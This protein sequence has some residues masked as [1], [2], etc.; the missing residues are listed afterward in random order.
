MND[1]HRRML[2]TEPTIV[3]PGTK[4]WYRKGNATLSGGI[5]DIEMKSAVRADAF[6]DNIPKRAIIKNAPF[7]GAPTAPT[8]IDAD[9]SCESAGGATCQ[10]CNQMRLKKGT[11]RNNISLIHTIAR[12][13]KRIVRTLLSCRA[14][15]FII[16]L[17]LFVG[18]TEQ[19][20][21]GTEIV[22]VNK[23]NIMERRIKMILVRSGNHQTKHSQLK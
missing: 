18:K 10:N 22:C 5:N 7:T 15:W 13:Q 17:P 14:F 12:H 9:A 21:K 20:Y 1:T 3:G 11:P 6:L 8:I 2:S 4:P 23:C 19:I 16:F